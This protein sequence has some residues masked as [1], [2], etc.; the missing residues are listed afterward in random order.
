MR[1]FAWTRSAARMAARSNCGLIDLP[2]RIVIATVQVRDARLFGEGGIERDFSLL[3]LTLL[4]G[5][6]LAQAFAA[7]SAGR[8]RRRG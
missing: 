2:V 6:G 3:L 1:A 7:R 4:V 8:V 5:K